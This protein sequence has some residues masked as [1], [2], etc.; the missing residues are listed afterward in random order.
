[1]SPPSFLSYVSTQSSDENKLFGKHYTS[2]ICLIPINLPHRLTQGRSRHAEAES[3]VKSCK[4]IHPEAKI[5]ENHPKNIYFL[6]G[7]PR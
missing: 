4:I 1:M 7:C 3:E 6:I 5:K 2:E